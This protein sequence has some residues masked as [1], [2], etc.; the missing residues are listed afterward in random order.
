MAV[1]GF[2]EGRYNSDRRHSALRYLSPIDYEKEVAD[3]LG[4]WRV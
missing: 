1:L 4:L 2:I 3:R